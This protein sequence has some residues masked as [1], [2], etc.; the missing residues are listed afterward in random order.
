METDYT[1]TSWKVES[2]IKLIK[3]NYTLIICSYRG[4]QGAQLKVPGGGKGVIRQE[5]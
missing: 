3:Y 4:N 5:C 1:L 2:G